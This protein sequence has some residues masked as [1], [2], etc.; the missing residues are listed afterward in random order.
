MSA[1]IDSTFELTFPVLGMRI[2]LRLG[3]WTLLAE[4]R[5]IGSATSHASAFLGRIERG[6]LLEAVR[7]LSQ[8]NIAED[9]ETYS[10]LKFFENESYRTIEIDEE[11][12]SQ[13][14]W[15]IK[16][17][18]T[19]P[20]TRFQ[21]R[22]TGISNLEMLAAE[23]ISKSDFTFPDE[24]LVVQFARREQSKLLQVS[25]YLASDF[26]SGSE[27]IRRLET[28]RQGAFAPMNVRLH[29]ERLAY[30]LETISWAEQWWPKIKACFLEL[31]PEGF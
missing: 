20:W 5:D 18:I 7:V 8:V 28:W 9:G 3:S 19:S 17:S 16:N 2:P 15:V 21:D 31:H 23:K 13:S 22:T 24:Y 26:Q 1:R 30:F 25:Y 29:P 27:S 11:N 12:G 14:A 4:L 6:R 10:R